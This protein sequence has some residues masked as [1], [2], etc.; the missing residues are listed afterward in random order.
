MY[1]E[2]EC[3]KHPLYGVFM[4]HMATSYLSAG[5]QELRNL[6][7]TSKVALQQGVIASTNR[8]I[9]GMFT[10]RLGI[11]MLQEK[12]CPVLDAGLAS[13]SESSLS[14]IPHTLLAVGASET[15]RKLE[16]VMLQV[17]INYVED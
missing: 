9:Y 5:Y 16:Q 1:Y 14:H 7:G 11:N 8:T 15:S 13:C 4:L 12:W 17:M 10:E 3:K 2:Q 6:C